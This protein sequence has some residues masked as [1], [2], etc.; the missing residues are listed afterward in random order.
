MAK[1][2][3]VRE[4]LHLSAIY[5]HHPYFAGGEFAFWSEGR[6]GDPSLEGGDVLVI[7]NGCVLVGMGERTRPAG[8]EQL[9]DRLFEA[10]AAKLVIA[11]DLPERRSAMHLDTVMT[12]ID[13]DA[14]TIYP[15][16]RAGLTAYELRP[17]RHG[18]VA[19]RADDAFRSIAAA[20]EVPKLRLFETGGD[21]Y[22]A[23]REQWDDGNN[24]VAIEPGVVVGYDRN[25]YT[26]TQL[27]RAGI[28]VITIEGSEL[29]RG[30]GGG[31]CMTCPLIRDPV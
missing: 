26:N 29:G 8:V 18:A 16:V 23:E 3:R 12:M 24:V 19:T 27:R 20:L 10:G 4:A 17:G 1:P 9:A 31:H 14:F 28:E 11:L 7:G 22:E 25:V 15:D 2:A 6:A 5:R 30:R 13:A 21:R